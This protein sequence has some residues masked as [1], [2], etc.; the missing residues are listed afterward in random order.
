MALFGDDESEVRPYFMFF[1]GVIWSLLFG[2]FIHGTRVVTKLASLAIM[3]EMNYLVSFL[4]FCLLRRGSL[5]HSD[6]A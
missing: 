4:L 2:V 5:L 1:S 3:F 6:G